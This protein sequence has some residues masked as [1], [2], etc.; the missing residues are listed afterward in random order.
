MRHKSGG[1]D[2]HD[3]E[4]A[5]ACIAHTTRQYRQ[6]ITIGMF[7]QGPCRTV[8]C[9]RLQSHSML[10][11]FFRMNAMLRKGSHKKW[12]YTPTIKKEHAQPKWL[13]IERP[14]R[15]FLRNHSAAAVFAAFRQVHFL[16]FLVI[17]D[18]YVLLIVVNILRTNR[19]TASA[20]KHKIGY[21]AGICFTSF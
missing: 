1:E 8:R 4:V 3:A 18:A 9:T 15:C 16:V 2:N 6:V 5:V 20:R 17:F 10:K 19:I 13:S 11:P 7:P 12:S 21:T 14:N